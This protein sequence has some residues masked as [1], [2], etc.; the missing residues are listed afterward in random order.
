[1]PDEHAC[2]NCGEPVTEHFARV[3]GD[4]NNDVHACYSCT[5]HEA[6]TQGAASNA[7]P[8]TRTAS[9]DNDPGSTSWARQHSNRS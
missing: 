1:M 9:T 4:N 7:G 5:S 3:F 8:Q 2:Q 6:V